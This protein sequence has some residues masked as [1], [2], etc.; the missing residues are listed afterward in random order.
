MV[1]YR[2]LVHV[3]SSPDLRR[4]TSSIRFF[5]LKLV[6]LNSVESEL[7]SDSLKFLYCNNVN[8]NRKVLSVR[9]LR[10]KSQLQGLS[11]TQ[12]KHGTS[13]T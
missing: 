11:V 10:L 5:Q 7:N 4:R 9:I 8:P 2:I 12:G 3:R 6:I 1:E 13:L